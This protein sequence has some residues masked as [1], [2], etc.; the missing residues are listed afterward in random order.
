MSTRFAGPL[1]GNVKCSWPS[2]A[3]LK[4]PKTGSRQAPLALTNAKHV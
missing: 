3:A 1:A 4:K 2:A